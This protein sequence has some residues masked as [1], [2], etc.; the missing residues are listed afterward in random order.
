MAQA[1]WKAIAA[2]SSVAWL[3]SACATPLEVA[4]ITDVQSRTGSRGIDVHEPRRLAGQAGVPDFAGDQLLEVRSYVQTQSEGQKEIA[5]AAC[6]V[7]AA[8]FS[9][10]AK[11]PAKVRVPLYR[12][13]SSQLAV[14]CEMPG[15]KKRMLTV[16]AFDVTRSQRLSSGSQG[17]LIGAIAVAAVDA[18][19]DNTKNDWKYPIAQVVLE[20]EDKPGQPRQ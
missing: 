5:G 14:A 8:D 13:Q 19:A 6:T 3:V 15:Y 12:A 18:M 9:A 7:S 11:T 17:G 20:P 2:V 4:S 1:R 16:A 10:S